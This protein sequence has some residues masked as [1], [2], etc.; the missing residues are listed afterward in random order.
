MT[1]QRPP[2]IK[3]P[4][5]PQL[6]DS[7]W[8]SEQWVPYPL[9]G[10]KAESHISCVFNSSCSLN[11]ITSD[12]TNTFFNEEGRLPR[13]DIE[14]AADNLYER[15]KAWLASMPSCIARENAVTPHALNIQYVWPIHPVTMRLLT[16]DPRQY[17]LSDYHHDDFWV[18]EETFRGQ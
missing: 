10:D 16:C 13:A 11:Q 1:Y 2:L 7:H 4:R 8:Q 9:H 12:L 18:P 14:Q 17:E 5:R 3:T 15:L 6:P